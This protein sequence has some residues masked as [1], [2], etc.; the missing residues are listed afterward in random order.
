MNVMN[1]L[2]V[3]YVCSSYK[4]YVCFVMYVVTINCKFAMLCMQ[5]CIFYRLYHF[6]PKPGLTRV[7]FLPAHSDTFC[8]LKLA[9]NALKAQTKPS[10]PKS[11]LKKAEK[12]PKF[13]IF[14]LFGVYFLPQMDPRSIFV[15]P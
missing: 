13:V 4:L 8:G 14:R 3:G 5:G 2:Y 7:H 9:H 6:L 10:T 11:T 15:P 12:T 1:T